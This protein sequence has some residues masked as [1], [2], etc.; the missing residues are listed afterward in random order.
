MTVFPAT[1]RKSVCAKRIKPP[2]PEDT[3]GERQGEEGEGRREDGEGRRE[4]GEEEEE[5]ETTKGF[6]CVSDTVFIFFCDLAV[7]QAF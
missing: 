5:E 4:E 6:G 7:D 2:T 3:E 1:W